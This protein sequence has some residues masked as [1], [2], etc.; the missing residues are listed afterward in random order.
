MNLEPEYII[1][2]L[3]Q[4]QQENVIGHINLL[5]PFAAE[6]SDQKKISHL[7]WI[8]GNETG[9]TLSIDSS[10]LEINFGDYNFIEKGKTEKRPK[11]TV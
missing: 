5:Q 9:V 8:S 3:S 11:T 1:S 10:T 7:K 4:V 6:S 2:V